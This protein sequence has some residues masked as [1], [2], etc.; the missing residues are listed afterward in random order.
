MEAAVKSAIKE[1]ASKRE[2]YW[3]VFSA[4]FNKSRAQESE[5]FQKLL[6]LGYEL[7]ED[8]IVPKFM[9]KQHLLNYF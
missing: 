3:R 1:W 6:E 4:N 8:S 7:D 5:K 2:N 9:V